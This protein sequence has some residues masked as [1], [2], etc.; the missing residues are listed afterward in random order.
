MYLRDGN[1]EDGQTS[2]HGVSPCDTD[3]VEERDGG[4]G[5]TRTHHGPHKVIRGQHG[6]GRGRVGVGEVCQEG[7]VSSA[8]TICQRRRVDIHEHPCRAKTE[9]ARGN[10][11]RDPVRAVR[12]PCEPEETNLYVSHKSDEEARDETYREAERADHRH[13]QSHLGLDA[14]FELVELGLKVDSVDCQ[15]V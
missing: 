7:P 5:H 2:E 10:D 8:S 1:E 13:G 14:A 11:G 3:V 12:G 15:L 9:E 6:S 4:E